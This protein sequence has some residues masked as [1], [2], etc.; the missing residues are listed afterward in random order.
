M[1]LFHSNPKVD[2]SAAGTPVWSWAHSTGSTKV[3]RFVSGTLLNKDKT[4]E[5]WKKATLV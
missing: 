2:P 4:L 3:E 5:F 1:P